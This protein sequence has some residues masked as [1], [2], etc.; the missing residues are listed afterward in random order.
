LKVQKLFENR[1]FNMIQK[2]V[3]CKALINYNEIK[4]FTLQ[5]F[6]DFMEDFDQNHPHSNIP[7]RFYCKKLP[8]KVVDTVIIEESRFKSFLTYL[9]C[10][11]RK[12]EMK[13]EQVGDSNILPDI[14]SEESSPT[15]VLSN[16]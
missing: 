16:L 2:T 8:L 13:I 1:N 7:I 11:Y 5:E 6:M 3:R 10:V 15:K 4:E 12:I 14:P 9:Y